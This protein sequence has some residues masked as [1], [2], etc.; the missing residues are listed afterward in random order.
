MTKA[1]LGRLYLQPGAYEEGLVALDREFYGL[2]QIACSLLGRPL[3]V[4]ELRLLAERE[5]S[6]RPKVCIFLS[7]EYKATCQ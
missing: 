1:A 5:A 6:L 7:A 2:F 3:C 4:E